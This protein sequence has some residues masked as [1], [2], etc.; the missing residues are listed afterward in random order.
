MRKQA[1]E[2][3]AQLLTICKVLAV[4]PGKVLD[5]KAYEDRVVVCLDDGR[6]LVGRR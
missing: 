4:D 3:D 5:W 2:V 1:P 6:K